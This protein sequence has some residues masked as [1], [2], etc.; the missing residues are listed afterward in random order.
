MKHLSSKRAKALAITKEVKDKVYE[1]DGRRCVWCG[2]LSGQ[3]NAHFIP[4]SH[5]GLGIE[6]NIL[7]LCLECH[8]K[9]DHGGRQQRDFMR[10][11]FARYLSYKYPG[12]DESN[13]YYR[14]E[15]L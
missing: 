7:T 15:E 2:S 12:W 6:Q 5:G 13:L 9:Y 1:R 8:D 14:K 11:S 10:L 3:P 4:R